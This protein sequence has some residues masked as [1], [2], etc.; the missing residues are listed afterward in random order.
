MMRVTGR[1]PRAAACL[2]A[3]VVLA[4]TLLPVSGVTAAV[5]QTSAERFEGRDRYETSVAIAEAYLDEIADNPDR[6]ETRAA[7]VV[8]GEDRHAAYAVTAAGLASAFDAPVLMTP[9]DELDAGVGEFVEQHSIELVLLVGSAEVVSADVERQLL[10]R[11]DSVRR[12]WGAD[13]YATSAAIAAQMGPIAGSAGIWG[14]RGHTAL[15]ANGE[16]VAD[17]L[18]AGPLS[19]YGAHP[20][21]LTRATALDAAVSRYLDGSDVEHIVI[22]GG[23]TAV[24]AAVEAA[25]RAKGIGITR[26]AAGDRYGTAVAVAKQL[27]GARRPDACFDG[28]TIGLAVGSKAPDAISSGPLLGERCAPLLLTQPTA[29]PTVVDAFLTGTDALGGTSRQLKVVAFGGNAAVADSTLTAVRTRALRGEPFAASVSA[30][31]GSNVFTVTFNEDVKE[32]KATESVRYQ[33]NNKELVL[34]STVTPS[35]PLTQREYASISLSGR[36]VT[37]ELAAP[38]KAGDLITVIGEQGT[39]EGRSQIAVDDTLPALESVFYRVPA[40]PRVTDVDGPAIQIV[41]IE[42]DSQ[43]V[44]LVTEKQLRSGDR[45]RND[46]IW[47]GKEVPELTVV[48]KDGVDREIEFVPSATDCSAKREF[49]TALGGDIGERCYEDPATLGANFRYTAK[50][51]AGAPLAEGDVITVAKGALHDQRGNPNRLTRYTVTAHADNGE[52]GDFA[53]SRAAV[54]NPHHTKQ[55]S[56]LISNPF[57]TESTKDTKRLM[58]TARRTGV[59][60]GA[61][62]NDWVVYPYVDP[63]RKEPADSLIEVGVDP[64]HRILSYTIVEGK[65]TLANLAAALNRAPQFRRAFTARVITSRATDGVL[66]IGEAKGDRLSGGESTVGLRVLFTDHVANVPGANNAFKFTDPVFA[67]AFL[68]GKRTNAGNVRCLRRGSSVYLEYTAKDDSLMPRAS[69]PI[70]I[71]AGMAK[72]TGLDG[73]VDNIWRPVFHLRL[74]PT[75]PA[76]FGYGAKE[77]AGTPTPTDASRLKC[78]GAT[79]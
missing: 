32:D 24:G 63:G 13:A 76:Q 52:H 9:S 38:L 49:T 30:S 44:V 79:S 58:I 26:L 62:G 68:D 45:L 61:A 71:P 33:V 51:A 1:A 34:S 25:V 54:G 21:L 31:A 42:G 53:V 14:S 7:I 69:N 60:A 56:L 3:A 37:V 65:I 6:A 73:K 19:Y 40:A 48:D 2:M 75:I 17:A 70:H 27:L 67:N 8:S 55:A 72:G 64:V 28:S 29:V 78:D 36:I 41:A 18:V 46:V 47:R 66:D 23:V 39:S 50:L 4:G 77:L 22:L 16:T 5:S 43:F 57:D 74:D 59:A 35:N 15:L 10:Q 11:I 12:I 20:L